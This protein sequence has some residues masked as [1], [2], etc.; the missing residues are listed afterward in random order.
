MESR[1]RMRRGV[2]GVVCAAALSFGAVAAWAQPSRTV[3]RGFACESARDSLSCANCC[4]ALG[5]WGSVYDS[6]H[7]CHCI[8]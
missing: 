7:G 1:F 2:F 4:N 3:Q 6:S 8:F 5:A